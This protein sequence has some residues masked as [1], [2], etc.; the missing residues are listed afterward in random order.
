MYLSP[1]DIQH[2]RIHT[3]DN[4]HAAS[5]AWVEATERLSE[6][7]LRAGRLALDEGRDQLEELAE[8]RN[9]S[10][11]TLPLERFAEW[12]S[13]SAG[14]VS[15]CFEII[16]D[17]HQAMLQMAKDQVAVFDTVLQRQMDR[18]A[19]SA[20]AT[21]EALIDHAREALRQAE[22]GFNGFADAAAQGADLVEEQVRQVS[23]ALAG[24]ADPA[25]KTEVAPPA[26]SRRTRAG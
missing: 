25:E 20:D 17:A 26:R 12:R 14:L 2:T 1:S 3:I 4:L 8:T 15:E 7:A 5:R 6:L 13:E 11:D 9:F 24:D 23:E 16:G 18:A 19:L 21:G 10:F 22:T